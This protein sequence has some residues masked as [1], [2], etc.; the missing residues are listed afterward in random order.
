MRKFLWLPFATALLSPHAGATA[1]AT[2]HVKLV[3]EE[4]S[5]KMELEDNSATRDLLLRLPLEITLEDF[6]NGHERIFYPEPALSLDKVERGFKPK[7]GDIAIFAPWNNVAFFLKNA[8]YHEGLVRLGSFDKSR[9]ADLHELNG[10]KVKI[11][12]E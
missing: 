8:S 7:A 1:N 12:K 11:E 3:Y 10:L 6:G 4:I 9:I 2:Y 5:I